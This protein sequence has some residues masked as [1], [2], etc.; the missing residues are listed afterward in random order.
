M[1]FC[2]L[3]RAIYILNSPSAWFEKFTKIVISCGIL[4]GEYICLHHERH[5][6]LD[7]SRSLF[8]ELHG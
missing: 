6:S 8:H 2:K 7:F 1:N 3:T 4:Y 5:S